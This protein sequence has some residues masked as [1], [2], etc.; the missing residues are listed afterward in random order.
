MTRKEKPTTETLHGSR[1]DL[2][3]IANL[4]SQDQS[5]DLA[6]SINVFKPKDVENPFLKP[7]QSQPIEP[8]QPSGQSGEQ[9]K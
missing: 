8:Q 6:K 4:K 3:T 1:Q 9:K 7:K 5:S 2:R